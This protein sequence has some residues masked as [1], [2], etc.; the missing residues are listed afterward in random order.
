ML[1]R[2]SLLYIVARGV[3]AVI[4]VLLVAAY[5]RLLD[6]DDFGLWAAVM[7]GV[8]LVS[9]CLFGWVA[10]SAMRFGADTTSE[11]SDGRMAALFMAYCATALLVSA[12][13]AIASAVVDESRLG[14]AIGFGGLLACALGWIEVHNALLMGRRLAVASV[15]LNLM[16][17]AAGAAGGLAMAGLGFGVNGVL[18]GTAAGTIVPGIVAPLWGR[19]DTVWTGALRAPPRD[20][21]WRLFSY[22]MPL[23]LALVLAAAAWAMDRILLISLSDLATYGL[24]AVGADI[25]S[26]T[27]QAVCIPIGGAGLPLANAA[28]DQGGENAARAQFT[29]NIVM[30]LAAAMP[31]A[32][33]LAAVAPDLSSVLLDERYRQAAAEVIPLVAL[34][35]FLGAVRSNYVEHAFHVAAR[36]R[37]LIY[38]LGIT[39]AAGAFL[40]IML[41]PGYGQIG[42]G[43]AC[44]GSQFVG[45]ITATILSRRVLKLPLPARELAKVGTATFA[46]V[47]AVAC[48]P[49]GGALELGMKVTAGV[50]VYGA[51]M[52]TLNASGMRDAVL[53]RFQLRTA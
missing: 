46:M 48:L 5:T 31:A 42:A 41:I 45:L 43:W 19:A 24:Y 40:G 44:V 28:Y 27:L 26:R 30:L 49:H 9:S 37:P 15:R 21:V 18:A 2:H 11:G 34:G 47:G 52:L 20:D 13:S 50:A 17:S 7:T 51:A 35:G 10:M 8:M 12:S 16:R 22:G 4:Y 36:T 3:P 6:A 25:V 1:V 23:A 53:R 29:R 33:G 39:T 14:W 32:A 38:V